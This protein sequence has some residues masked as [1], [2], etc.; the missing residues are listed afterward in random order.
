M[1]EPLYGFMK[2]DEKLAKLIDLRDTSQMALQR[3]TG[4]S[5][6][7]LSDMINHERKP[8]LD[9]AFLLSRALDVSLEWL[10]DDEAEGDPPP[11]SVKDWEENILFMAR[12][13]GQDEAARRLLESFEEPRFVQPEDEAARKRKLGR[14]GNGGY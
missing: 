14:R 4:I 8:R 2:F 5:Q 6:S 1:S 7:A 3:K 13:L 9:Q 12:K 10:A 11:R